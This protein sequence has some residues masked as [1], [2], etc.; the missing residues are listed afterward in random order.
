M[1]MENSCWNKLNFNG[2][3]E[4]ELLIGKMEEKLP[5]F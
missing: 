3:L 5:F 1:T 2:H 4:E